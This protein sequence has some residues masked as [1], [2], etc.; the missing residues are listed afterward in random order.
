MTHM[1]EVPVAKTAINE[2]RIFKWESE[3]GSVLHNK[4]KMIC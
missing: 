1:D 2:M 3:I 4:G